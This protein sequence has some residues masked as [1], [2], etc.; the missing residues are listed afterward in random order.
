MSTFQQKSM[1]V[2]SRKKLRK[3]Q[4]GKELFWTTLNLILGPI[5]PS[6]LL[7]V[8]CIGS[9]LLLLDNCL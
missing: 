8:L 1:G 9:S 5:A 2:G 6:C 3:C 4:K 7:G